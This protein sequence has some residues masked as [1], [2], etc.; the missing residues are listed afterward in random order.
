MAYC[1]NCGSKLGENDKFCKECGTPASTAQQKAPPPQQTGEEKHIHHRR[2]RNSELRDSLHRATR[3][4][5]YSFNIAWDFVLILFINFFSD[6]IAYYHTEPGTE[7]VTRYPLITSDFSKWVP[8]ATT[9]LLIS[10]VS[11]VV[12]IILDSYPVRQML[13]IVVDVLIIWALGTLI[14]LFPFDFSPIPNADVADMLQWLL[15]LV[16]G[17]IIFGLCVGILV[18]VIK[19][20]A[21]AAKGNRGMKARNHN[22]GSV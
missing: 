14:V 21:F 4:T 22:G 2:T 20:I 12:M 5:A 1:V 17:L 13:R 9:A 18:R 16:L 8:V 3:I 11:Y 6:F 15:P 19:L 7:I 10:I